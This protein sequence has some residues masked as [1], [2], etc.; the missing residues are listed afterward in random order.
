MAINAGTIDSRYDFLIEGVSYAGNPKDNTAMYIS[1]KVERL[2]H[3]LEGR[4]N[5]LVFCESTIEIPEE[6]RESNLI[7]STD[8]PQRAYAEFVQQF[9]DQRFKEM[10]NRKYS[11]D[12]R[13]YYVGENVSIGKDCYIEPG[14][15]IGHDV[16]IGD[17]AVILA[18][19]IIKNAVIGDDFKAN[20]GAVI[21][22]AG[23]TIAE[24]ADGNKIRIPTL[25][26]VIIGNH[27]EIGT[28]DNISCGSGG[29]TV[30]GD[31]AKLDT[32][33]HI[34][35]DVNIGKNVEITAGVIV[36]G[37]ATIEDGAWIG[38]NACIRNRISIGENA[39]IGM[40]AVVTKSVPA[41]LTMIGNPAKEMEKKTDSLYIVMP[42]YQEEE[43]IEEVVRAWYPVLEG[44]SESSRIVIADSGSTDGTHEILVKLQ[45]EFAQLEILEN[46][47]KQ[48][49]PKLLA[50]YQYAISSK[51]DYIFQTDSDGQTDPGEFAAFW[52][53]RRQYDV[54]LGYRTARGDGLSR[55][56]V[57][58]VVCVLLKLYFGVSV[59]DANAPFR[60]MKAEIVEKY[61]GRFE[62]DYNLPN[63]M[64]T[65]FFAYYK[66]RLTFREISF[67]ARQKG[68][69]SINLIK[70]VKIGWKA[71]GDFRRFRKGMA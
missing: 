40:G 34:G 71:L 9:E 24:D 68:K 47:G 30:I 4:K 36:G 19:T 66:D 38:I 28:Q 32:L 63:I 50:L 41:R 70:I 11:L 14:C 51:A 53:E 1:K 42:A 26:K 22:A 7:V 46:T 48:H 45:K 64:L 52:D 6:L 61:I 54:I 69:N 56:L 62:S 31:Y 33:V 10:E 13:G 29:N 15:L 55:K 18:G 3:N 35:H 39:L 20:E 58:K 16:V 57:E 25:G 60:L 44:K 49:G 2:L 43:N 37:F 8:N 59:P 23:F 21:G 65:T 27:V 67:Q 5:C 17:R 12:Q